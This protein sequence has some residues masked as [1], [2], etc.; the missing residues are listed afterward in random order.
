M[1]AGAG[2]RRYR[3][4][5]IGAF[6][7]ND[8]HSGDCFEFA[9]DVEQLFNFYGGRSKQV[10]AGRSLLQSNVLSSG[11]TSLRPKSRHVRRWSPATVHD[12][13]G[14]NILARIS[15]TLAFCCA[16]VIVAHEPKASSEDVD[17]EFGLACAS[18]QTLRAR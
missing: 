11:T 12:P 2:R 4:E 1:S 5:N 18:L 6:A 16:V 17:H 9:V 14:L 8:D 3:L 13:Q 7:S 15:L 10:H